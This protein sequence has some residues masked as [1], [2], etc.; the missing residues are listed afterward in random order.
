MGPNISY[1]YLQHH[2]Q[3]IEHRKQNFLI[4]LFLRRDRRSQQH[5]C[6]YLKFIFGNHVEAIIGIVINTSFH[7][8]EQTVNFKTRYH[9]PF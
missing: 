2:G 1:K 3:E 7:G 6:Q 8:K 4:C 9:I 5:T